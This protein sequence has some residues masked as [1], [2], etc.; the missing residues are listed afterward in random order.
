[1]IDNDFDLMARARQEVW[2]ILPSSLTALLAS[3]TAGAVQRTG[4]AGSR[5]GRVAVVP[6]M[7]VISR[8][9]SVWSSL[10]GGTSIEGLIKTLHDVNN[11]PSIGTVVLSVDSPGGTV[12]GLPAAAAAVRKLAESKHV[13]AVADSLMAS[14]AYWIASQAHEI[15]ATPEAAI[16]SIGVFAMHEDL[17]GAL[18]RE[19]V[20]LTYI[21]A[22][23]YK[24]E[25]N[26]AQPLTIE[27]RA[28]MQSM[29]DSAYGLFVGDV[30][31]GRNVQTA[32]VRSKYGEGRVLSAN[33]AKAA[34]LVDRIGSLNAT[35]QR[36]AA[37]TLGNALQG[38]QQ[39]ARRRRL[40]LA[41]KCI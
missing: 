40:E 6:I 2:A 8:Y 1:M 29:V 21:H 18:A 3:R 28:H 38:G 24:V 33:T 27:A 41:E 17:S 32:T 10:F 39:A 4:A 35:L 23:K 25:G 34:G 11:D 30:A 15:V 22:G 9:D 16:G 26:P 5:S 20:K 36:A 19:G 14:A 37:G 13:V 7:G 12:S 31:R